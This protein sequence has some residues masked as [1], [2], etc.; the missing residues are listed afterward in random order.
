M[1]SFNRLLFGQHKSLDTPV[2][3]IDPRA[4]ILWTL[5]MMAL[6]AFSL[7]PVIYGGLTVYLLILLI[8]SRLPIRSLLPAL[9]SFLLLFLI[10]FILHVLFAPGGGNVY[11]TL[12]GIEV[13]SVG[14]ENGLL[15]SYRILL[16]LMVAT[17][18]NLTTSPVTMTEGLL[19]LLKP[20]RALRVPVAEISMMVFIALRFIPVLTDEARAIRASQI[21]RGLSQGRGPVARIR[22]V[23]PLLLPLL[24]GALRRA[25]HLALAIESRGYRKGIMR[26]SLHVPVFSC[27][28]A[29]FLLVATLAIIG[30]I[31]LNGV[32]S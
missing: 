27:G 26:T 8:L 23:I 31:V 11:F 20:L 30:L 16:F 29:V 15:Y 19:R 9:K 6:L 28:D 10:T 18:A 17:V 12:A 4:K 3:R 25:E 1:F 7:D 14:V 21:A 5:A 2:H 24:L 22:S 32:I 13:T